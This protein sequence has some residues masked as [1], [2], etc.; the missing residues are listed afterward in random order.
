MV[1]VIAALVAFVGVIQV[2][3]QAQVERSLQGQD[4]TSLAFLID[5]LHQSNDE[6]AQEQSQLEA[7]LALLKVGTSSAA[8]DELQSEA[9]RL[10]LVEGLVAVHGPGVVIHVAAPLTSID[11]QDA[12]NNLQVGGAEAIAIND[13]R[14]ITGSVINQGTDA[15]VIDGA[16]TRGPWTLVAIG[17]QD[18][19]RTTADLMTRS[20]QADPRVA[21]ADYDV[22]KDV[23][24]TAV[25]TPR[26]FVYAS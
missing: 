2:R 18:R 23:T 6:L 19:L 9:E 21:R 8:L 7:R 4:N 13:R 17:D 16:S 15:V 3:S 24:I 26:P 1:A 20:L 25:V 11:I 5:D 14:V 22:L 10:R 12:V